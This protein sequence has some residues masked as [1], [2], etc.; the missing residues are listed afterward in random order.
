[1]SE[2]PTDILRTLLITMADRLD[3]DRPTE[4]ITEVD[5]ISLAREL[6][7]DDGPLRFSFLAAL[8]PAGGNPRAEY[9]AELRQIAGVR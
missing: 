5:T 1:M 2:Q 6:S 7:D 9:A 3:H 4:P 8:P